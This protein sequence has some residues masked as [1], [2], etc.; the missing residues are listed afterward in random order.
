MVTAK[1]SQKK[2]LKYREVKDQAREIRT[3]TTKENI[4][5]TETHTCKNLTRAELN[6]ITT[7][8]GRKNENGN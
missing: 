4:M 2:Q 6:R 3:T 1:K 7:K 8:K 5:K